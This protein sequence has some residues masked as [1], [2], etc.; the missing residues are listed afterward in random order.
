MTT[1]A[2]RIEAARDIATGRTR[3]FYG[4]WIVAAGFGTHTIN[5]ALLFHAFGTY[6]VLLG[7]EFGWSRAA[8]AGAFAMQRVESGLLGPAQ[9]WMIDNWGPRRVMIAGMLIFGAGFMLLSRIDT[10]EGFYLAYL[11]IAVG[12]SLGTHLGVTVAVVHWFYRRRSWALALLMTGTAAGGLLQP[13]VVPALEE[14]GWRSGAFVSGLLVIAI[15]VPLAA[16]V[17]HR[18]ED[19]GYQMDGGPGEGEAAYEAPPEEVNFTTQQALRTRAFWFL[20]LGHGMAALVIGVIFV[21]FQFYANASLGFT[22]SAG[23]FVILVM[24]VS[25]VVGQLGG[26]YLADRT[27]KRL[28]IVC[29]LLAQAVSLVVLALANAYWMLIVFGILAGVGW[30]ARVPAMQALRADYFGGKAFGRIMGFSSLVIMFGMIFGPVFAGVVY[31][32]TGSYR[33]AFVVLAG[34]AVV[35]ALFFW[36][37]V[38]PSLPVARGGAAGASPS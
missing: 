16:A 15:G 8:L 12:A 18:P 30:G 34:A 13:V 31:D 20:A 27:N 23:A 17:R 9:G 10:I 3:I 37:A 26:G 5:G 33:G 14:F 32:V 21:H 25:T 19:H 22:L 4:W 1:L 28:M 24:T 38:K 7:D 35:G 2:S 11:V 29:A 36:L 6:V